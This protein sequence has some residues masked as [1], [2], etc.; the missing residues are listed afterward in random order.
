MK[1]KLITPAFV[2]LTLAVVLTGCDGKELSDSSLQET[3]DRNIVLKMA[4]GDATTRAAVDVWNDTQVSL[5]YKS[6]PST[7][8]DRSFT[9]SVTDDSGGRVS[10]GMKYS[11]SRST[12]S[13]IGY[14]P[15][16]SNAG[17]VV[18]YDISKGDL[19]VMMSNSVSG[20]ISSPITEK[21]IFEHK[22]TRLTFVMR[23]APGQ[24]YPEPIY[25]IRISSPSSSSKTLSKTLALNLDAETLDF[26][27]PG[28][29]LGVDPDGFVVP[30]DDDD[31]KVLDIMLQ[32]NVPLAFSVVGLTGD[33]EIKNIDNL[34]WT[35]L[36]TVG[37]EEGKQYTFALTFSGV[38]ILTQKITVT[39]WVIGKQNIVDNSGATTTWW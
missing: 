6:A 36:T 23:C 16:A 28:V 12:V 31:A 22:L 38:L 29:I 34:L 18:T 1:R 2:L 26:I 3:Q 8:F 11:T 17:G 32:P 37:G 39:P 4:I 25:G 10:T 24:S 5:A 13:F 20:T 35:T 7:L 30:G 33:Q 19:D 14:H 15:A 9:V 21:L 27:N